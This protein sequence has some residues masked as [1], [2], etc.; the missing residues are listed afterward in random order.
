M[1]LKYLCTTY[2][3]Y[4][5]RYTALNVFIVFKRRKSEIFTSARDIPDSRHYKEERW[6]NN[7]MLIVLPKTQYKNNHI[8]LVQ[9]D[10]CRTWS[11]SNQS[12][13]FLKYC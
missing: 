1:L 2:K 5:W 7:K 6:L 8:F 11:V 13:L 4:R 9:I 3:K 12:I 10:P